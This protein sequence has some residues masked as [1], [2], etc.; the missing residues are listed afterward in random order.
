M[1]RGATGARTILAVPGS[2]RR[3]SWNRLLLEAAAACAAAEMTVVMYNDLGWI[4][5]FNE[6][7]EHEDSA[8]LDAVRRLRDAVAVADGLLIAT[9]EY[10]QS[11][12]GVLKNAID[13][14][15]RPGPAEVLVGKP[16][17][18]IG[19]SGGRWGTRLA[20]QALR[21][22]LVATESLVMPA[23]ALYVREAD[24]LFDGA[25]RLVD[26]PTR[27]QLRAVLEALAAWIDRVGLRRSVP[28]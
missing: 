19:A 6:D 13:W 12:P 3:R 18:V 14:L 23:P 4:P 7:L 2:L 11:I 8:G 15:S 27:T 26:Q 10:N 24:R 1:F 21:G 17:A 5:P 28:A 25:G 22:V 20:Q 16:V 9:P